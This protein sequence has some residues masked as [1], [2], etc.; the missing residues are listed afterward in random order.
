MEMKMFLVIMEPEDLSPAG[1]IL[2]RMGSWARLSAGCWAVKAD[3]EDAVEFRE[4]LL[5]AGVDGKMM[6]IE[7]GPVWA[8]YK[9]PSVL[10]DWL[11][12]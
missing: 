5:Q 6:V 8:T 10:R 11:K 1:A 7:A 12:A 2:K 4:K 3:F 9:F